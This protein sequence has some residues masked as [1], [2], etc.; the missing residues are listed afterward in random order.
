LPK[1][2]RRGAIIILGMLALA[3]RNVLTDKV[4][5]LLKIGLGPYGKVVSSIILLR[6]LN[7]SS[8]QADLTLARYTC[9]ALQRLN[10][11]AKKV[12]GVVDISGF[13]SNSHSA[14]GSLLDKTLRIE[15]ESP[16][17]RRLQ[18]AIEQPCRSK[19]WFGLA[20]QAINTIYALGEHPDALCN[21]VIKKLT[22]RVFSRQPREPTEDPDRGDDDAAEKDPNLMDEDQPGDI[23]AITNA[24]Q[25]VP[26]S[27]SALA[28]GKDLGEA[29]ELSQ[30]LFVV[31][32]VAIKH[33]V[34]L[35]LV[36][37]EWKRQKDER[38]AGLCFYRMLLILT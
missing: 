12:K 13:I 34:Y 2:Q 9:V 19:D 28:K 15:M 18:D 38:A 4:D 10:G 22:V 6:P 35:E 11:S 25:S 3:N 7:V 37:R 8:L 33:I 29:F 16:I 5:V 36:E 30:L 21:D 26:A 20:E 27:Q 23:S 31:G 1:A 17:F 24:T 14:T 32:H